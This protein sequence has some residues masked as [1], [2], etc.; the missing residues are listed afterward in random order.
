VGVMGAGTQPGE[1][2]VMLLWGS[3]PSCRASSNTHT[4]G[5][6]T[7]VSV[8]FLCSSKCLAILPNAPI[9][10]SGVIFKGLFTNMSYQIML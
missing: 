1:E 3:Y 10:G 5:M 4:A 9:G 7:E 2:G 6:Q 8:L